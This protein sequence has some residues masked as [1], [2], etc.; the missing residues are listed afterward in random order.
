MSPISNTAYQTAYLDHVSIQRL[1]LNLSEN[2]EFLSTH[3]HSLFRDVCLFINEVHIGFNMEK[4]IDNK[5]K[6]I[7]DQVHLFQNK[8]GYNK[9]V[10]NKVLNYHLN[11]FGENI[12]N[13]G[14]YLNKNNELIGSTLYVSFVYLNANSFL[15]SPNNETKLEIKNK[16]VSFSKY[17]G[18]LSVL[19]STEFE[20]LLNT[21]IDILE[22]IEKIK[23]GQEYNNK[24]I[25]HKSLYKKQ[26]DIYNTFLTRIIF[27]MQ[28][29]NDVIFIKENYF[30]RLKKPIFL[31]SYILLRLTTL[32]TDE[33]FDNLYNLQ[34]Y[35]KV[36]FE[37]FDTSRNGEVSLLLERYANEFKEE[38]CTMRNMIH[39][40][41][42][43][44]E[45]EDNFLGYY[46]KLIEKDSYEPINIVENTIELY[47]KPLRHMINNFL[48]IE[49]IR[50]LSDFEQIQIRLKEIVESEETLEF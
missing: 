6:K 7:R 15:P 47:L 10:Y 18:E 11:K 23:C 37:E 2:S 44:D 29:I 42:E 45:E 17:V 21:K 46:N 41:L 22:S 34:N 13:I 36:Y 30:N 31:D 19:L 39:Y 40:N 8:K 26:E 50:S 33:T 25:N 16:I 49:K 28:E 3:I 48:G 12:N 5:I 27:T 24:D 32:K 9:K 4:E 1:I 35:C 43:S 14:F 20:K 38:C